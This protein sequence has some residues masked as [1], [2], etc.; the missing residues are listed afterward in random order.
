MHILLAVFWLAGA[1]GVFLYEHL[2]GDLRLRIRGTNLSVAWLLL[3]LGLYNLARW[4]GSRAG[5]R[6]REAIRIAEAARLRTI[7]DR[8]R[9]PP[10]P[11]FDFSD[12]PRDQPP[13][14]S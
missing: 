9:P 14:P 10:D 3:V 4:Y 2:S 5:R 6:E 11:T 12:R 1:A 13:A 7:R 8:E